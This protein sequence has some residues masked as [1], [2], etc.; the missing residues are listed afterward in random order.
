ML[1]MYSGRLKAE[2]LSQVPRVGSL[3]SGTALRSLLKQFFRYYIYRKKCS[4]YKFALQKD[5]F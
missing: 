1:T 4:V 2:D 5:A 3:L